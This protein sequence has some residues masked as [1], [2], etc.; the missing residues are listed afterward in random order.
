MHTTVLIQLKR[1]KLAFLLDYAPNTA[2]TGTAIFKLLW[3]TV[4]N[5]VSLGAVSHYAVFNEV[6]ILFRFAIG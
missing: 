3:H 4:D 6:H 1:I 5:T 2:S